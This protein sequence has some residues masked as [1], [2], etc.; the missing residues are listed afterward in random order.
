VSHTP[1]PVSPLGWLLVV[2]AFVTACGHGG[3]AS[4]PPRPSPPAEWVTFEGTLGDL[5][6]TLPPDVAP[7]YVEGTIFAQGPFDEGT[8]PL[9]VYAAGPWTPI[10]PLEPNE[11]LDAW[12]DRE[13]LGGIP[14]DLRGSRMSDRVGLPSGWAQRVTITVGSATEDPRV[15]IVWAVPTHGRVGYVMANATPEFAAGRAADLELIAALVEFSSGRG[16][17][18]RPALAPQTPGITAA[19][20]R[21]E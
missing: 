21:E 3:D 5:R 12:I 7:L 17:P 18:P 19:P 10:A 16:A 20:A 8:V 11:P 2:G 14:A 4:L 1:A 13:V 6:V 15:V 9:E